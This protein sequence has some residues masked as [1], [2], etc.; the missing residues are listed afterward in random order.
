LR[1]VDI[2][3]FS[4]NSLSFKK[5]YPSMTSFSFAAK[6]EF[7]E[8]VFET[9]KEHFLMQLKHSRALSWVF[10]SK[11]VFILFYLPKFFF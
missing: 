11:A 6:I 3:E 7:I 5:G 2:Q 9:G 1:V 4:D 8:I 10:A